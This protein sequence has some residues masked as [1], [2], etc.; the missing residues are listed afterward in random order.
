MSAP[1][2]RYALVGAA[3]TFAHWLT[4]AG[5][6]E[7]AHVA[8][9]LASGLGAAV[10]AQLAFLGNRHFTFAHRG[11]WGPAWWRFMGTALLGGVAGMVIVGAGVAL[12]LHYLLAQAVATAA[13]MLGTY[14][15]NRRW[16]F[17]P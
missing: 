12:G 5:L 15:V 11:A 3:A 4:L 16:T 17:G 1:L 13:V 7:A 8:P 14:T 9:W 10:G 6:V 2:L